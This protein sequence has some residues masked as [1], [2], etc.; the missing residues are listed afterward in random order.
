MEFNLKGMIY[1]IPNLGLS[2]CAGRFYAL[3]MANIFQ[4]SRSFWAETIGELKKASWPTLKE[5]RSLVWVIIFAVFLLGLYVA[6]SDFSVYNWVTLLA[7]LV[8]G[9]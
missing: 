8:R 6:I 2:F 9:A 7:R 4:K 3:G 5:L 1:A